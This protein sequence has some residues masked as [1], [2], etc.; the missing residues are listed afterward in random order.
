MRRSIPRPRGQAV[1]HARPWA[2]V[3][4]ARGRRHAPSRIEAAP[5]G[6]Y[7]DDNWRRL[8]RL[9]GSTAQRPFPRMGEAVR[10]KGEAVS[11]MV[12]RRPCEAVAT[13]DP[14]G[15]DRPVEDRGRSKLV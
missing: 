13:P 5:A 14:R 6:L 8:D 9:D 11:R 4:I 1:G 3:S 10:P 7:E 12:D 15:P 2:G